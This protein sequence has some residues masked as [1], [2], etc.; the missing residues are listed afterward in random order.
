[1]RDVEGNTSFDACSNYYYGE[2]EDYAFT[3]IGLEDCDG[4]PAP[5]LTI[6]AQ[7]DFCVS[8][9]TTLT[10]E[11]SYITYSGIS[12]QWQS[13]TDGGDT[14]NDISGAVSFSYTTP[15][16]TVTTQYRCAVMCN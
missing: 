4:T 3:V 13:S 14:W 6:A 15:A 5:G 12:W 2:T 10:L 11:D 16:I 7:S 9:S 1:V 8:G